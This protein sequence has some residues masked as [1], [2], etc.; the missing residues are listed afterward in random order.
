MHRRPYL[1]WTWP[2]DE[3]WIASVSDCLPLPKGVWNLIWGYARHRTIEF[4][5][6]KRYKPIKSAD[7]EDKDKAGE[8]EAASSQQQEQEQEPSY[9]M[10]D[11]ANDVMTAFVPPFWG[12]PEPTNLDDSDG[13]VCSGDGEWLA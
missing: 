13:C 3:R 11:I 8:E 9:A 10:Y 2:C 4:A 6:L 5:L 7:D 1:Q 12:Q